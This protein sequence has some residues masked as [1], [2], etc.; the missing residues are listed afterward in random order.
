MGSKKADSKAKRQREAAED[1][2]RSQKKAR[3][4]TTDE[5]TQI[6][7]NIYTF[8][9]HFASR[10]V[11]TCYL[12]RLIVGVLPSLQ[13]LLHSS[14]RCRPRRSFRQLQASM[15][16]NKC[17]ARGP[18]SG[19]RR[20]SLQQSARRALSS[21]APSGRSKAWIPKRLR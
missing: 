8:I 11:E 2:H 12:V 20:R 3:A 9:T 19:R 4:A 18:P 21:W 10:E 5:G 14:R 6:H 13:R 16:P 15:E 7:S 17:L 1:E